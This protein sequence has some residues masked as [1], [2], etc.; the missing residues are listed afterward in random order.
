MTLES[1]ID[2]RQIKVR[3][4]QCSFCRKHGARAI[5]DPDGMLTIQIAD[6][7]SLL[8]YEFAHRTADFLVCRRCGVYVAAVTHGPGERRG[9][10]Q[11]N[12][13][14]NDRYF[15]IAVAVEYSEE[16]PAER[17]ERRYKVWMPVSI[18]IEGED[19]GKLGAS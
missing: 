3:A 18:E 19:R 9:I 15:G 10:A 7:D 14:T 16:A 2:P 12:A 8:R 13:I 5:S 11:L 1:E 6:E 17:I 4:C